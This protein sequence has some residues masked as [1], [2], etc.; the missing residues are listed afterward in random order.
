MVRSE[1]PRALGGLDLVQ[2]HH[3]ALRLRDGLL[4]DDDHV[5]VLEPD[6][7]GNKRAEVGSLLHLGHPL[8]GNHP[9]LGHGR[10]VSRRPAT[11]R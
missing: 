11:T 1:P 7:R 2:P 5:A 3:T 4:R 6:G 8:E 9:Q 10:P